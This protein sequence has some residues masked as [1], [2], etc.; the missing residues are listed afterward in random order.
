MND[1]LYDN[2]YRL[3]HFFGHGTT[4]KVY[5]AR[6][7]VTGR[8]VALKIFDEAYLAEGDALQ[9]F[10]RELKAVA[11]LS[12]HP[13]LLNYYGGS[14]KAGYRY[15]VMEVAEGETLIHYL[16]RRGGRLPLEEA[17]SLFSQLLSVLS[18]IHKKGVIH[19][20]VKP[21]NIRISSDGI[22]KLC[23]FGIAVVTGLDSSATGK[24]VGTVF[25][26]SPEQA[27]GREVSPA[28]D[29]Y[30]AA[31]L[32]YEILAGTLPFTS[33]KSSPRD[34]IDEIIRK[35]L[36]EMP[37]RPSHYN[38]NIPEAIE[39]I[40]LK[41]MSKNPESRFQTADE[42]LRYLA[43]YRQTTQIVFD[44]DLPNDEFDSSAALPSKTAPEGFR[45]I[46]VMKDVSE[47]KE[48]HRRSPFALTR[49]SLI[50]ISIVII[51]SILTAFILYKSLHSLFFFE[52]NERTVITKGDL[53]YT[54]YS[55]ELQEAL[56]NAGYDVTVDYSFSP[57][58]E[59]GTVIAQNPAPYAVQ[60]LTD[61]E[62]PK[63]LLTVATKDG[64]TVLKDYKGTDWR[65]AYRELEALGISVTVNKIYSSS[66]SV[67]DVI[68]TQPVAATAVFLG[69]GVL[70]TVSLGEKPSYRYVPNLLG[71]TLVEAREKLRSA[72][73]RFGS[74]R[75]EESASPRGT[76]IKQDKPYGEKLLYE[77]YTV[78]VTVSLGAP[79]STDTTEDTT[80]Q[81]PEDFKP[82]V[83]ENRPPFPDETTDSE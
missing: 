59:S 8:D 2:R 68:E 3:G 15:L 83:P 78:S 67:G 55:D 12:E 62:K 69:E 23:D 77:Y 75:Y 46:H 61:D 79:D 24:A 32:F 43:L 35:H 44:F 47:K 20:D 57:Y 38:P 41:A 49:G 37:V 17:I 10:E 7:T 29:L 31:V 36:K 81:T 4:A 45:P 52:E 6:D 42:M 1:E 58:Y 18:Y 70:L 60:S 54:P 51:L 73:I 9:L 50:Y 72:G 76:V 63:L 34:R 27:K 21:Q 14:M 71:L 39:Q 26:I 16:N 53:L 66:V 64:Y 40:I 80:E 30:S 48:D 11:R 25:Y 13:N 65:D 5:L 56:V 22:L 19:R 33:D 74:L 28:S 82:Q